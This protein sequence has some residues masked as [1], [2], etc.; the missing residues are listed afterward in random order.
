MVEEFFLS[1]H[2]AEGKNRRLRLEMYVDGTSI[3]LNSLSSRERA[4]HQEEWHF[5]AKLHAIDEAMALE[6][7][8]NSA[9]SAD[10]FRGLV[11]T[12]IEDSRTQAHPEMEVVAE[13]LRAAEKKQAN[14]AGVSGGRVVSE[15]DTE[16]AS[17]TR[18]Q[19]A[20][21][22]GGDRGGRGGGRGGRG[23]GSGAQMQGRG[24]SRAHGEA[25]S[26]RPRSGPVAALADTCFKCG[27]S[28]HVASKC[29]QEPLPA[30]AQAALKAA[31]LGRPAK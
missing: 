29:E 24:V 6:A 9:F 22:G 18:A 8:A 15:E 31:A 25:G 27:R 12:A 1:E 3:H 28:G 30:A 14:V 19:S 20:S 23:R 16:D 5:L 4:I 26:K 7:A 21:R 10:H 11:K 2:S 13:G 17:P